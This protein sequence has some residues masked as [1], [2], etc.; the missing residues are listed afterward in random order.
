MA[1]HDGMDGEVTIATGATEARI[2]IA[3]RDDTD[4][5]PPRESFTVTLQATE[6]QMQD[7]G[8]GI[9]TV[10]EL[11]SNLVYGGLVMRRPCCPR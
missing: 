7:F 2:G 4:I 3:I 11:L 10:R 6:A 5:E 8:L 1:V 9:A